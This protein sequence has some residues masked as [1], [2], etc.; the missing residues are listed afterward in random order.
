ME[1]SVL[2]PNM[3]DPGMLEGQASSYYGPITFQTPQSTVETH[4]VVITPSKRDSIQCRAIKI[5]DCILLYVIN[6]S[7]RAFI[8]HPEG[9]N[10]RIQL[11]CNCPGENNTSFVCAI[12]TRGMVPFDVQ[13]RSASSQLGHEI[14]VSPRRSRWS[15]SQQ[16][17]SRTMEC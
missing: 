7:Q 12:Y 2:I 10:V 17:T 16:S 1:Q 13:Q 4:G 8:N 6:T 3:N 14:N 5:L 15:I 11:K 9:T